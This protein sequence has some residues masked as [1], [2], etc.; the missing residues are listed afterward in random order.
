ME[1]VAKGQNMDITI[2]LE[3][4]SV[5]GLSRNVYSLFALY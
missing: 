1:W 5:S 3:V 4:I 2:L